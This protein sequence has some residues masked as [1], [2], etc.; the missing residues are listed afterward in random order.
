M[1]EF[2]LGLYENIRTAAKKK[3]YSINRLEQELNFARSYIGKFK[4]I[5]PGLDKIQRI[6][7]F[8]DV[9][10]EYLL[11][12]DETS[13]AESSLAPKD[14]LDISKTV[15]ELM[16]KLDSNDGAPLFYD[17]EE[18]DEQT[19]LLFRNQLSSLVTTV[20]EINKVKYNPN[21]N[22]MEK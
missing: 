19:K 7:E 15:N 6:A 4:T 1:E 11:N 10:V 3:G 9:P 21:K 8:L 17:G 5:T 14:K 2:A 20:K 16:E 22:K 12:G 18:M 13:V